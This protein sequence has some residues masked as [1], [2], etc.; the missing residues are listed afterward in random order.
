MSGS[1]VE[2]FAAKALYSLTRAQGC[3]TTHAHTDGDKCV[4]HAVGR[5][6]DSMLDFEFWSALFRGSM[7]QRNTVPLCH[8][9]GSS[10][11]LAACGSKRSRNID[12]PPARPSGCQR[13]HVQHVGLPR[14]APC[15]QELA[16]A[17]QRRQSVSETRGCAVKQC[18]GN[19]R[20]IHGS[21]RT[22]GSRIHAA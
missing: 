4:E 5:Y 6:R 2:V 17:P 15:R 7:T 14:S 10:T 21:K 11:Y 18:T 8:F 1:A 3:N 9:A 19:G 12:S 20:A 22:N 13:L 16:R